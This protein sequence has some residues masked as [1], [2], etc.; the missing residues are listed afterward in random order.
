MLSSRWCFS[1]SL[2][3]VALLLGWSALLPAQPPRTPAI[4]SCPATVTVDE[5]IAS[6]TPWRTGPASTE[7]NF[8]RISVFNGKNGGEE[9]DLAPDDEQQGRDGVVQTW[10]LSAYRTMN[11]FV[12]C[13]YHDTAAVLWMDVPPEIQTCTLR[14]QLDKRGGFTGKSRMECR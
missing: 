5:S 14:F 13:R 7:R 9:F 10:K 3:S 1:R 6:S 8:E 12:R 2:S 4:M 11:I